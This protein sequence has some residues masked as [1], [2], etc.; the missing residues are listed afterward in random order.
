MPSKT[1]HNLPT[2]KKN[3]L[4][5]VALEEFSEKIFEKVKVVQLC[6][7]MNIPRV[8]FYSYFTDLADLY[9]YLLT[10]LNSTI[11]GVEFTFEEVKKAFK[12][13]ERFATRLIESDQGQRIIFEELKKSTPEEKV[14]HYIILALIR[15]Y[16]LKLLTLEEFF[17]EYKMLIEYLPT[18]S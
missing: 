12:R 11:E 17:K 8:T 15:Q 6:K 16:Q 9:S 10:Y 4:L 18:V 7:K 2:E 5:D 1:F 13:R 3:I 14:H